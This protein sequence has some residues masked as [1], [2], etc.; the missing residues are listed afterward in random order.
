MFTFCWGVG[1]IPLLGFEFWFWLFIVVILRGFDGAVCFEVGCYCC[2]F[3]NLIWLYCVV[4]RLVCSLDTI[5]VFRTWVSW[6]LWLPVVRLV[7]CNV[8][9]MLLPCV[10]D[11]MCGLDTCWGGFLYF[12]YVLGFWDRC[13]LLYLLR[14]SVACVGYL[15]LTFGWLLVFYCFDLDF[16]CFCVRIFEGLA[17]YRLHVFVFC[18]WLVA[19][20]D[21][22][23]F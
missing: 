4:L 2:L 11:F 23:V 22:F 21:L 7:C 19:T 17:W 13:V 20:F 10:L 6:C 5:L 16:R 8:L 14:I 9:L 18:G 1:I 3:W 15:R 12:V